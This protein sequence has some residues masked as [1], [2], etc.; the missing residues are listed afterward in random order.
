[1]KN[2]IKVIIEED[3]HS[4]NYIINNYSKKFYGYLKSSNSTFFVN[5]KKVELDIQLKKD[6]VYEIHYFNKE[7]NTTKINKEINIIY[8]TDDILIVDKPYDLLTIPSRNEIDSLYSRVIFHREFDSINC[9][10]RLDKTTRGLVLFV[11]K[12]YLVEKIEIVKKEYLAKCSNYLKEE[13]GIINLPIFKSDTIK[14]VVDK[15]GKESIT[16]YK[17]VD[18]DNYIYKLELL[19]G[20]THQIRVHLSYNNCPINGDVLYGSKVEGEL[21]LIC[22]K[23]TF[24]DP[25]TN[26]LIEVD[27]K[28]Q[29]E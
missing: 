16:K 17:L 8:E 14:R 7:K 1:M 4:K 25:K 26:E 18:K 15:D 24:K 9:L 21:M 12:H 10:T 3:I 2:E 23:L 13:E 22:N 28:Y 5:N 29:M 6:D 19:T 27:S 11:K 20:R